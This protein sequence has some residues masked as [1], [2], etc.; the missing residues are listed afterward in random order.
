MTKKE[1]IQDLEKNIYCRIRP[2]RIH[3]V[4]VFAIRHI[5]KGAYPLIS[6]WDVAVVPI[7]EKEIIRN[8]KIHSAVKTLVRSFYARQNGKLYFPAHS[9]NQID[10]SY[11][12]NHSNNPNLEA[13]DVGD[14]ILFRAKRNIKVGEEL[15]TDYSTFSD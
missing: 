6:I 15:T 2:S 9:F 13:T 5:P 7:A 11:F 3:G 14:D 12:L 10:I 1:I 8:K 4:G